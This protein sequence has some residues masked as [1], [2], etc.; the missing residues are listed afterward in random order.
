MSVTAIIAAV[1]LL[2]AVDAH[3]RTRWLSSR[4]RELERQQ[5][6]SLTDAHLKLSLDGDQFCVLLGPNLQ[7]GTAGFGRTLCD[8]IGD[9]DV[10]HLNDPE[11]I[12]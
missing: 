9:F 3:L 6:A 11:A 7:E 12:V 8:A 5:R 4:I 1:A 10:N 2:A